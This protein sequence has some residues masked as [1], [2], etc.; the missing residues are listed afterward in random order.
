MIIWFASGNV[1]KKKEL[2]DILF[3]DNQ[4][5]LK[6]SNGAKSF[7]LKTPNDVGPEFGPE[8]TGESFL[9]NALLKARELRRLLEKQRP[10]AYTS[11]DP[12]IADDS[13]ICV[14]A[15]D[16]RPGIHS[17]YYGGKNI[18]AAERNIKLLAELG[19]NPLRSARFICTMVLDCGPERFFAAQE[20]LEGILVKDA[21]SAK[22]FNGFGY[23]PIFFIPALGRTVAEL[24]DEEK[25]RLGHRGKAGR[26]IA[27]IISE[28][29]FTL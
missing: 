9:A 8:E 15:L 1:H 21:E 25:N 2:A 13:G 12:V 3:A 14:D 5:L 10:A 6:V 26:V 29:Y 16:G 4:S 28:S 7:E 27:K 23:D 24:S 20:K 19:D 17:A 22:G 18:S 11:E